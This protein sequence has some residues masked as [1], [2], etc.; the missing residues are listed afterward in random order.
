MP[1]IILHGIAMLDWSSIEPAIFGTLFTRS[2][3]P[4]QRAKLGA[5]YTSKDDIVLIVEPVLMAPLR[6]SGRGPGRGAGVGAEA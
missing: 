2:L 4:S 6:R 5:Q 3:D 1:S